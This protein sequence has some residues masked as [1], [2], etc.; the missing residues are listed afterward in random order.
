[1]YTIFLNV[2]LQNVQINT[3]R[4]LQNVNNAQNAKCKQCSGCKMCLLQRLQNVNNAAARARL[5]SARAR[6][7]SGSLSLSMGR[8]DDRLADP[9][10]S[11]RHGFEPACCAARQFWQ[12]P[13]QCARNGVRLGSHRPQSR[14]WFAQSPLKPCPPLTFWACRLSRPASPNSLP[15]APWLPYGP[16]PSRTGSPL[17][18]RARFAFS[19]PVATRKRRSAAA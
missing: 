8:P 6:L 7:G 15:L 13:Y 1:M 11:P 10:L 5:G 2:I 14:R 19:H 16:S 12:N 17:I 9:C 4:N 18:S 3:L